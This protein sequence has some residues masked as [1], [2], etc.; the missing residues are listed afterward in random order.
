MGVV[1]LAFMLSTPARG[2]LFGGDVAVLTNIL[3]QSIQQLAKLREIVG[4]A[5]GHLDLVKQINQGISDSLNVL[6]RIHPNVDPGLYGDWNSLPDA[7]AKLEQLYG[8]PPNSPEARIQ[9]DTDQS[10]AEA[11]TFNNGF[12]AYTKELDSIGEA[13][14]QQ[15]HVASPV[16][17]AR[18]TAQAMGLVIQVLNQNLRAQ[19]TLLKMNAQ[20]IAVRNRREK[21]QTSQFVESGKALKSLMKNEPV[22]FQVPRF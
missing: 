15:S 1:V 12:Y 3:V 9:R 5:Q 4:T 8:K 16:G 11:V 21:A 7:L 18:M 10:I 17:A 22:R 14:Q 2:D 19:A 13:I 6:K 20:D